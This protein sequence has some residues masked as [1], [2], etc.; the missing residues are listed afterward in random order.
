MGALGIARR[1]Q[2]TPWSTVPELDK[3][4]RNWMAL[5]TNPGTVGTDST[6]R[7]DLSWTYRQIS[8]LSWHLQAQPL[9]IQ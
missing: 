3:E 8:F 1:E 2:V 9:S 7:N 5:K 4:S 6:G